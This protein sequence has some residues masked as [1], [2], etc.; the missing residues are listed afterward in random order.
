MYTCLYPCMLIHFQSCAHTCK[1]LVTSLSIAARACSRSCLRCGC[2]SSSMLAC[3][4][5]K[6][7]CRICCCCCSCSCC[8]VTSSICN[9]KAASDHWC[10]CLPAN[11]VYSYCC[12]SSC[13]SVRPSICNSKAASDQWY[14][15]LPA[16]L[17]YSYCYCC[18]ICCCCCSCCSVTS[19]ICNIKATLVH[20]I[21]CLPAELPTAAAADTVAAPVALSQ[22]L[23]C[24]SSRTTATSVGQLLCQQRTCDNTGIHK[25]RQA[26]RQADAT[27]SG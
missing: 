25:C 1:L 24:N 6:A 3:R 20:W 13:C 16:N 10:V 15:C 4:A 14:I 2:S 17:L 18:R 5:D 12:C 8:S 23:E 19:S 22:H 11:V 21:V 9:S 26:D 27:A 7:C